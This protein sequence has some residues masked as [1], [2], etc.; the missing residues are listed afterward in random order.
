M[1]NPEKFENRYFKR[2]AGTARPCYVCRSPTPIVLATK[3]SVDFIYTCEG[4]LSD[5]GFASP[6]VASGA[7]KLGLSDDEIQKVKEDWEEKQR[8]KAEKEKERKEKEKEKEKE[9]DGEDKSKSDESKEKEKDKATEKK[10]VTPISP[11]PPTTSHPQYI[12]HRDFFDMRQRLHRKRRQ[13]AQAREIAPLLPSAPR[14]SMPS[15]TNG[16]SG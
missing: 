14:N 1:S 10:P 11:P 2:T 8:R 6:A 9:K 5:P 15:G 7:R 3:D 4:H 16:S 12:L 13:A